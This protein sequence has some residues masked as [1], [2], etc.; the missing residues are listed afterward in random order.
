MRGTCA[1]TIRRLQ[2][3]SHLAEHPQAVS[4]WPARL[5]RYKLPKFGRSYDYFDFFSRREDGRATVFDSTIFPALFMTRI[6]PPPRFR[7]T[8]LARVTASLCVSACTLAR[9]SPS[10]STSQPPLAFCLTYRVVLISQPPS[11]SLRIYLDYAEDRTRPTRD[12]LRR[13]K[14]DAPQRVCSR[15]EEQERLGFEALEDIRLTPRELA[16]G[17]RG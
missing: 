13:A 14:I 1:P 10:L 7:T 11:V 3:R 17:S 15:V 2:G 8:S 4:A 16:L 12:A 5:G 9:R 6:S